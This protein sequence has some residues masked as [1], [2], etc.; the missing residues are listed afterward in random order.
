MTA[1]KRPPTA[2][3]IALFLLPAFAP[4]ASAQESV[5]YL[6]DDS[7][8]LIGVNIRQLAAAGAVKK[9][10]ERL[11]K[12]SAAALK[13]SGVGAAELLTDAKSAA[14]LKDFVEKVDWVYLGAN[15][16]KDDGL[17]AVTGRFDAAA[18]KALLE[19]VKPADVPLKADKIGDAPVWEVG[20]EG[21]AGWV[22]VVGGVLLIAD[23]KDKL[24]AALD[25]AAGKRKTKLNKTVAGLLAQADAKKSAWLVYA[26]G[27]AK[28]VASLLLADDLAGAVVIASE[29]DDDARTDA[30]RIAADLKVAAKQAAQ[31]AAENKAYA[32]LAALAAALKTAP[33][34]AAVVVSL[35]LTAEEI[36]KLLKE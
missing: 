17:V 10:G 2:A 15:P 32:P 8:I 6:P 4:P 11:I 27:E 18:V 30:E 19:A 14:A 7:T 3:M 29:S 16:A 35:K 33:E 28:F 5:K 20:R 12:K 21:E 9:F 31:V 24:A 1:L 13:A 23:G 34:G 26:E 25:K 22:G 36:E